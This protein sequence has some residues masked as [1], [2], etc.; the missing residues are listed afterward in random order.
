[1]EVPCEGIICDLLWSDPTDERYSDWRFNH[2]RSCSYFY[3]SDQAKDFL[4]S[5]KMHMIIRGHEVQL[6][7]FKY[8]DSTNKKMR[9]TLTIFSAPNYCDKYNNKGA[10]GKLT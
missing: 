1:V 6:E 3:T 8:Q 2:L 10:I 4:I 5:N 9:P 7:G